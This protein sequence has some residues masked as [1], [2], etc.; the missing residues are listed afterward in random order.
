MAESSDRFQFRGMGIVFF[1]LPHLSSVK[2]SCFLQSLGAFGF[3]LIFI[4]LFFLPFFFFP[5]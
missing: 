4:F 2:I 5:F 1:V 3:D